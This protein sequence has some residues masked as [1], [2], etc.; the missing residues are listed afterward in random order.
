MKKFCALVVVL[1]IIPASAFSADVF[2]LSSITS[3]VESE[4]KDQLTPLVDMLNVGLNSNIYS[5]ANSGTISLGVQAGLTPVPKDKGLFANSGMG[6]V[7]D[8]VPVPIYVFVASKLPMAPIGV[9]ARGL[10]IPGAGEGGDNLTVF[11]AGAGFHFPSIG[12]G[13]LLNMGLAGY[14]TF[15]TITGFQDF[16][17]TSIGLHAIAWVGVPFVAGFVELGA[18]NANLAIKDPTISPIVKDINSF[19][20]RTAIGVELLGFINYS[21][22]VTPAIAHNVSLRIKLF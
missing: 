2:D 7:P 11:G 3:V 10:I 14:A 22:S 19:Q 18:A 20:V 9:F 12:L 8:M 6:D 4:I 17:F 16:D 15:H 21:L 1:V 13:P 5:V